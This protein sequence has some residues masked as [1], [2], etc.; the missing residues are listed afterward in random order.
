[1]RQNDI[2]SLVATAI[3]NQSTP[4]N[5]QSTSV[6]VQ[7]ATTQNISVR[8]QIPENLSPQSRSDW[9][10]LFKGDQPVMNNS[11]Y[12][13]HVSVGPS[14]TGVLNIQVDDIVLKPGSYIVQYNPGHSLATVGAA[15][16][17]VIE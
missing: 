15:Y 13:R 9:I 16:S 10:Y 1:M 8:Y 3:L 17:F 7:N 14:P 2:T 4:L 5:Y 11:D 6:F 12:L